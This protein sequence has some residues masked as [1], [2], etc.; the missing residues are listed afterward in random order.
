[1][2]R[3]RI[4]LLVIALGIFGCAS[5]D[6]GLDLVNKLSA[7]AWVVRSINVAPP[8][9]L[10]GADYF[11][12]FEPCAKDDLLVMSSDHTYERKEGATRCSSTDPEVYESGTWKLEDD[13]TKLIFISSQNVAEEFHIQVGQE[14]ELI[15]EFNQNFKVDYLYTIIYQH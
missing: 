12:S 13:N 6:E 8:L 7:G 3:I 2:K 9:P 14:N 1:M 10:I 11:S 4:I 15:L 5:K